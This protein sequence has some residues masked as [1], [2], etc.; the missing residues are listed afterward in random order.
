MQ[1][2]GFLRTRRKSVKLLKQKYHSL[3]TYVS[4]QL[5]T[6]QELAPQLLNAG[7]TD[8]NLGHCSQSIAEAVSEGLQLDQVEGKTVH[9]LVVFLVLLNFGQDLFVVFALQTCGWL[10]VECQSELQIVG[11]RRAMDPVTYL[12]PSELLLRDN[13]GQSS[14]R[15]TGAGSPSDSVKVALVRRGQVEV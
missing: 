4:S 12:V 9:F 6:L 14:S 13:K 10:I 7:F 2:R 5:L 15:F 3:Q 11:R 1:S 8:R